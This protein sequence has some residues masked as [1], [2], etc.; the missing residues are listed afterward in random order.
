[1]KDT[2][3]WKGQVYEMNWDENVDPKLLKDLQQVYGFL[4]NEEGK[5]CIVKPGEKGGWRLP[6]GHPE[7]EDSDWKETIIRESMEEADV[8]L[9]PSS[10]KILGIIKNSPKSDNC[11]RKEGYALRVVGKITNIKEQTEDEAEGL[12]NERKFIDPKDFLK[13]CN[14]GKFGEHIKNLAVKEME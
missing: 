5:L 1:M 7:R 4:F 6:G 11:E 8:E 3:N 14:W 2:V 10:L 12:I 13:Y 9:D